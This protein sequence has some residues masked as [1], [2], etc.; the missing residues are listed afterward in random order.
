MGP[1]RGK[2]HVVGALVWITG[3]RA[4]LDGTDQTFVDVAT[5]RAAE[6]APVWKT[7]GLDQ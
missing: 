7:G 3:Q 5:D 6:I 1:A 2:N 4:R